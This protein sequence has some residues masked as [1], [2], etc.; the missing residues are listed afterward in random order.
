MNVDQQNVIVLVI[1]ALAVLYALRGVL[2]LSRSFRKGADSSSC[3]SCGSCSRSGNVESRV[4]F[5]SIDLKRPEEFV[6]GSRTDQDRERRNG[7][8]EEPHCTGQ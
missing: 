1:V 5:V 3:G 4:T 2:R 8:S 6:A 7:S